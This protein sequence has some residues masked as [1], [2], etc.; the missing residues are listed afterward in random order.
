LP[1][2]RPGD[3]RALRHNHAARHHPAAM[4]SNARLP[5]SVLPA[6]LAACAALSDVSPRPDGSFGISAHSNDVNARVEDERAK[7]VARAR[8]FCD[9]RHQAMQLIRADVDKSG[10]GTPPTSTAE[11]RCVDTG[12]PA[13][14]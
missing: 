7:V 12:A 2:R 8:A 10:F 3:D 14:N 13:T 9:G 4:K 1:A 5:L 6:V 11:F